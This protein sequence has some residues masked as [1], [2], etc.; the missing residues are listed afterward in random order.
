MSA[1]LLQP[2]FN[3]EFHNLCLR[4]RLSQLA[5]EDFDVGRCNDTERNPVALDLHDFDSDVA[6]DNQLITNFAT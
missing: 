6:I 4:L 5:T 3:D 2:I 1:N